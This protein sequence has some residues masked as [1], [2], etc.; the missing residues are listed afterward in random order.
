MEQNFN[1]KQFYVGNAYKILVRK[2][3]GKRLLRRSRDRWEDSIRM[4]LG[5]TG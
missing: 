5:E 1:S 2:P 4:Y 3:E